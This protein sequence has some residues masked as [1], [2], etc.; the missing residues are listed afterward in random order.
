MLHA[1][2]TRKTSST[3]KMEMYIGTKTSNQVRSASPVS[4]STINVTCVIPRT[5]MHITPCH[6]KRTP[7]Y[8]RRPPCSIFLQCFEFLHHLGSSLGIMFQGARKLFDD[9]PLALRC[10]ERV[11]ASRRPFRRRARTTCALACASPRAVH[12]L[13][14]RYRAYREIMN[15]AP[16]TTIV[17][18][19]ISSAN[20]LY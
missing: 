14:A 7:R 3:N 5:L 15:A 20:M 18:L 2:V 6:T 11:R 1:T 17:I 8:S 13:I 10:T 19:C 9:L 12:L 4:F 16:E